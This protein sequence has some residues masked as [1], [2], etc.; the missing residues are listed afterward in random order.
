M[1]NLLLA[2]HLLFAVFAIGPL[3]GAA[4]VAGRGVRTGDG[5]AVVG[6]ARTVRIYGYLSV[7]VAVFG[8]AMVQ[9]KWHAKFSY[10]WVWISVVLYV[11]ALA[12]T[13][14]VLEPGLR[15]AGSALTAGADA[16][17]FAARVAASGGLI[18]LIYAVIIF[19]MVY[20]PH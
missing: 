15:K 4:S 3:V 10:P 14:A 7:L 6:S 1:R 8:L 2:L 18:A 20:R 12:L 13:L 11:I 17:P 16:R 19:L 5:A 9:P